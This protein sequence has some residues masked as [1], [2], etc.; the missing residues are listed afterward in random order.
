[1]PNNFFYSKAIYLGKE[2]Y[3]LRYA[4]D[5]KYGR[6]F[7]PL[8]IHM[9]NLIE[10]GRHHQ[11]IRLAGPSNSNFLDYFVEGL[12]YIQPTKDQVNMLYRGYHSY[13]TAGVASSSEIVRYICQAKPSPMVCVSSSKT[14]HSCI[15]PF[16]E[17]LHEIQQTYNEYVENGLV[18]E[19]PETS[20][21]IESLMKITPNIVKIQGKEKGAM[22][23]NNTPTTAATGRKTSRISFTG[24][25]PYTETFDK[26]LEQH[27]FFPLEKITDL[28]TSASSY[29][30]ACLYSMMAATNAR[31][32]EADQI[33]WQDINLST[34]EI[35]LVNPNTRQNPGNAYRG[36]SEV[37]RNKLEWKGRS[38]PLT[39]LLEPYGTLFFH[40][41]E[42][43]IRYEYK[44]SCG[45]N[46]IFHDKSGKPLYLCDYSSV[47]LHQ[48]RRAAT[49]ALPDQP[50]IARKL[51]LHSLRHS[52]IYFLKNYLE[53]SKGQGL[54]DSELML[55]TGHRDI[56]S[57][58]KYAKV[59]WEILLEKISHA[60][61]LRK[62]GNT[63]SSTE[64]QIQYLEERL[65][66]FKEKLNQQN[67]ER[68]N[69][70]A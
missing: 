38:T 44:A 23:Q 52:N 40:N 61:F 35:F 57:L 3:V 59:D 5:E 8:T 41:L 48:F 21:L 2:H 11:S 45:H 15:T 43:Y 70:L 9:R 7:T 17:G 39:V 51:G 30:N 22:R 68:E 56:R 65:A 1:M 33:L 14:Y 46:F 20:L 49:K 69:V 67:L 6:E 36:I 19:Q 12:K 18:I 27:Q 66:T 62:N 37:E 29:R 31:D 32:S 13:L 63:K 10:I 34:R 60:N 25:I 42:L 64:F 28:I 24:H 47:I 58:Q 26:T 54:S 16:L 4:D 50:H 55:L 53:H